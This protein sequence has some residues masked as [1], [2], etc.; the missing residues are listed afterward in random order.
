VRYVVEVREVW[1]VPK[2]IEADSRQHA[3]DL[4]AGGAYGVQGDMEYSH[5]LDPETWTV[6]ESE[7]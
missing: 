5:T 7:L 4:I 2:Y 3:I 1:V 6:D